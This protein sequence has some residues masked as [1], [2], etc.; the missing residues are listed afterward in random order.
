MTFKNNQSEIALP[1]KSNQLRSSVSFL[2]RFFRTEAN[3]KFLQSTLDQL[4]QPG[5]AE[6]INGYVGRKTSKAFAPSDNYISDVSKQRSDYQLEPALVIKDNIDNVIFYKDYNDYMNQLSAFGVDTANHDKIN[7]QDMY[8]WNPHIDWDKFVNFREYYWLPGGPQPVPVRAKS[9]QVIKTYQ[10]SLGE[11]DGY[12]HYIFTPDGKTANPTLKLFRGERYRFEINTPG[13]PIAFAVSRTFTPG[14]ALLVAGTEGLRGQGLYDAELFGNFYDLGDWIIDPSAGSVSFEKDQNLSTIYPDG[15]TKFDTEG[16]ELAVVYVDQGIIEFTIPDNSPDKLYYISKYDVNTSGLA[17]IFNI[18]EN[19]EKLDVVNEILGM[20]TYRSGNGIEFTNG[21]KIYFQGDVE[22]VTYSDGY[23]YVE[24]VGDQINLI[25]ERDLIIPSLYTPDTQVPFDDRPF[26]TDPFSDA[27]GYPVDKDYIVINRASL[28][29]NPWSLNNRWF[30]RQVIDYA[31]SVT[32]VPSNL[33]Q[34]LRAKRPIIE[35]EA[36]LKLYQFGTYAKSNVDLVDDYTQDVFST[37]EGSLGYNIDSIDLVDGMRVLFTADTDRLVNGRIY[38]VKFIEINGTS[39]ISL[40]NEPDT[41]PLDL[42]TV[43]VKNG[44][45]YGGKSLFFENN[46][47]NTA[48]EK[49]KRNQPPLFQLCCPSGNEYSNQAIFDSTTFKGNKIFSYAVGEGKADTELGFPL[50]YKSIENFG[51]IVFEFNLLSDKI[52]FQTNDLLAEVSTST[53]NLKKYSSRTDFVW[54]NGWNSTPIK[55]KQKVLR[56]YIATLS[57]KNMFE[58]DM[59]DSAANILDLRIKVFVN[60]KVKNETVD[61]VLTKKKEKLFVEFNKN[62][63]VNDIVLFKAYSSATKNN[64]GWYEVPVNLERNPLNNDITY[65]TLGEVNDHVDSMIEDL[66]AF[67]G[68]FPGISNLR[69]IGNLSRYGKRFVK[70]TGPLNLPIYHITNKDFNIVKAI[71]SSKREYSRFKRIF[72]ETA[73]N[74]GYD[75]P[76]KNHVDLLMKEI[77]KDKVK[78]Q[79]FYFSDMLAF[80]NETARAYQVLESGEQF[81]PLVKNFNLSELSDSSVLV[82]LNGNQLI[83]KKHYD[84]INEGFVRIFADHQEDD[85]IEIFE[86]SSTNGSFIPPTPTKLGFYPKFEP[87]IVIDDTYKTGDLDKTKPYKIYGQLDE[88]V[89]ETKGWFYPVYDSKTT[90]IK[91]DKQAGGT[92]SVNAY[93]FKGLNK[94]LYAPVSSVQ[95]ATNNTTAYEEYPVG[96]AFL[97]GHD[98]SLVKAYQDFRDDLF[99]ELEKRIFN[100]IKIEYNNSILDINDFVSGYHRDTNFSKQSVDNL[101][102]ND[103]IEW[104][105]LIDVDYTL[106]TGY[107]RDDSF[108]FNHSS[109]ESPSGSLLPGYWRGVYQQL[110]DTDR[111][112]SHPWEALGFYIKPV[113]WNQ[114]YGPAPYTSNNT[115]LW[116]DIENGIVREPN[117]Q[118]K[119]LEKYARPGLSSYIPVDEKGNLRSPIDSGFA[120]NFFFRFVTQ[121]FK[122]GDHA[123]VESAWR[124]SSEYPF[125]LLIAWTLSNPAKLL[126]LG[127]DL[128]RIEQNLSGQMVYKESGKII[129]LQDIVFPNTF[130]EDKKTLTSGL[131]NYIYNFVASNILKVYTEY[132]TQIKGI[133]NQLGFKLAGFS[134]KEKIKLILDSRSPR[135]S[136]EGGVFVPYEN[137]NLILNTS[138]PIDVV[139]YSGV[140]V[141]KVANGYVLRGYSQEN[142]YFDYYSPIISNNDRTITVGGISEVTTPWLPNKPYVKDQVIEY[143]FNFYR[144]LDNFVSSTAFSDEKL[145]KLSELP[146]VGGKRATIRKSFNKKLKLRINYGSRLSTSQDIVDFLLGYESYLLD[147][148]FKFENFNNN[149]KEIENWKLSVKEFLFWTTQ[150]WAEGTTIVLSPSANKVEFSRDFTVVDDLYDKFYD[151]SILKSDGAALEPSFNSIARNINEFGI[152]PTD[153]Q[154]GIYHIRLPLVQKEHVVIIDNKTVFGD[155]IYEPTTGYRQD[156]LEVSGYRSDNWQGSLNIPGF[157][158]DDAKIYEWE[159]WKDF[160]I[161]NIVKYK[162]FYYVAKNNVSGS[163]QFTDNDWIRLSEKPE[164]KLLTNF[165]YRTNQFNDFY[166]TDSEYFDEEQQRLAQHLTGYQ[167]REYLQNLI[168]DDSSQYKFYQGFIRE[169]GTKNSILKLFNSL[170]ESTNP[171]EFYEEWAVQLGQYGSTNSYSQIEIEI[172][173]KKVKE[174]PQIFE[175]TDNYEF[176]TDNVYRILPSEIYSKPTDFNKNF[177]P[178]INVENEFVKTAG[179]VNENDVAFVAQ[180]VDNI[181][182]ADCNQVSVN[183]YIWLINDDANGWNVLQH[184]DTPLILTRVVDVDTVAYDGRLQKE[185]FVDGLTD[186]N[187]STGEYIAIRSAQEFNLYGFYRVDRVYANKILASVP[188]DNAITDFE[189]VSLPMSKLRSIRIKD[190]NK[191]KGS[192]ADLFPKLFIQTRQQ[193]VKFIIVNDNR[194]I[195]DAR[196]IAY[197]IFTSENNLIVQLRNTSDTYIRLKTSGLNIDSINGL[198]SLVQ[199][200]KF[201]NQK[202]WIDN[203]D[204]NSW[205]VIK[206]EET[207]SQQQIL[208]DPDTNLS[209]NNKFGQSVSVT[210]DNNTLIVGDPNRENGKVYFYK[211]NRDITNFVLSQEIFLRE[212]NYFD[213]ENSNFGNSVSV[214]EDGLFLAIGIPNASN[215]KTKFKRNFELNNSYN[216]N[217]IVKYRE[218]LW[219]AVRNIEPAKQNITFTPFTTFEKLKNN[220]L[221]DNLNLLVLGNPTLLDTATDHI[222]VRAPQESFVVSK[223][224]DIL[225]LKWNSRSFLNPN[226]NIY[227]PFNGQYTQINETFISGNH[228][229]VNKV[230]KILFI[231]YPENRPPVGTIVKTSTGIGR[232]VY[233]SDATSTDTQLILYIDS[234]NGVLSAGDIPAGVLTFENG[235][236]I[237][238]YEELLND[239]YS[240][241]FGGWWLINCPSVQTTNNYLENGTGLVYVDVL[242]KN[243]DVPNIYANIRDNV[244]LRSNFISVLSYFGDPRGIIQN[245][246]SSLWVARQ[247]ES[248]ENLSA[249]QINSLSIFA[250][251]YKKNSNLDI[252]K[253]GLTYGQ[254]ESVFGKTISVIDKWIGYI[255]YVVPINS[256]ESFDPTGTLYELNINNDNIVTDSAI[257]IVQFNASGRETSSIRTKGAF[258]RKQFNNIRVYIK[259]YISGTWQLRSDTVEVKIRRDDGSSVK[260]IVGLVVNPSQNIVLSTATPLLV[261]ENTAKLPTPQIQDLTEEEY[262]FYN[263][264]NREGIELMSLPPAEN[265]LNYTQVFNINSDMFGNESNIENQGAVAIYSRTSNGLYKPETIIVSEY[266]NRFEFGK[267]V[268]ITKQND[269]YHLLV[270]CSG[271]P[272]FIEVYNHGPLDDEIYRKIWNPN[273]TYNSGDLVYFDGNF[274]QAQRDIVTQENNSIYTAELWKNVSWRSSRDK[275][276]EGEFDKDYRYA[277]DSLVIYNGNYYRAAT[278]ITPGL[279]DDT[280]WESISNGLE[281]AGYIPGPTQSINYSMFAD[282]FDTNATG[283]LIIV[284]TVDS[285][286]NI[287]NISVYRK[288]TH[289]FSVQDISSFYDEESFAKAISTNKAGT[290]FAVSEPENDEEKV[291]Q[292]KVY[293]YVYDGDRFVYNQTLLPPNNE[294]AEKF[295]HSISV[296]DSNLVVTSINGDMK[297]PATFDKFMKNDSNVGLSNKETTFDGGFT[298]FKNIKIDSGSVYVFENIKNSL[299]FGENIYND[300]L[301]PLYEG[302]AMLM[303]GESLVANDNHIYAITINEQG[304]NQKGKILDYRRDKGKTSWTIDQSIIEPADSRKIHEAFLYDKKTNAILTYVDFIDPVQGRIA[305]PADQDITYKI[306]FD[307]AQYTFNQLRIDTNLTATWGKEHVGEVWWKINSAKFA[308]AYQG[309]RQYQAAQWNKVLFGS[310]EVYEWVESN[311]PP[312]EWD[313]LADTETGIAQGISGQSLY[314]NANYSERFEYDQ[315]SQTFRSI[316]YFWVKDKK[317]VP[318]S[319]KRKVSI[320]DIKN[321]IENP[322][323]Q[324]YRFISFLGS[325]SFVLNNCDSFIKDKDTILC[326]RYNTTQKDIQNIHTEY[327]LISDGLSTSVPHEDIELKWFNS[328]IGFDANKRPVPDINLPIKDRYGIQTEPRQSMFVNRSEALKQAVERI[329]SVLIKNPVADNYNLT[330]LML[331]ELPPTERSRRYDQAVDQYEELRF[332]KTSKIKQ[333]ILKP[334][335]V[336]GKIVRISIVDPGHG[337]KISPVCEV[338][339]SGK[340]AEVEVEI[341]PQTGKVTSAKVISSGSG[342]N[343]DTAILVRHFTV[344][345]KSDSTNFGKWALYSWNS[346]QAQWNRS[347]V[348]E[349]DVRKFWNYVDWYANGYNSFTPVD[350]TIDGIY[351]L[352]EEQDR[353]GDVVKINNIGPGGWILLERLSNTQTTD[354]TINYKTI[355]R[356]NGTIQFSDTLYDY[357]K[358]TIGFDNR[359]FDSFVF[360]NVPIT[361]LRIILNTIKNDIFIGDL[362]V[363]YNQL[364]MASL[365][366]VLSE[367]PY[368]DWIFKTSFIKINHSVGKLDQDITFDADNLDDYENYVKEVKPYSTTIREFVSTYDTL[369]NTRSMITDFDTPPVFDRETGKIEVSNIIVKDGVFYNN[370][371]LVKNP[372]AGYSIV[373][374]NVADPG[375]GYTSVPKIE[376]VGSSTS[377]ASAVAYI[378][379]GKITHVE[380]TDTGSGYVSRPEIVLSNAISTKPANLSAVLGDALTRSSKISIKYDRVSKEEYLTTL[381]RVEHFVGTGSQLSFDLEWPFDLKRKSIFVFVN[382]ARA[383]KSEF[384]YE[385]VTDNKKSY[386]RTHGRIIFTNP[387]PVDSTIRVEYTVAAQ[388]LNAIDRINFFYKPTDGMPG[389][390]VYQDGKKDYSQVVTGIDYGGVE[391]TGVDFKVDTGWNSNSWSGEWD[392]FSTQSDLEANLDMI[393]T[394][395]NLTYTSAAGIKAEDI[396]IDGDELIS[397]ILNAGPEELVEGQTYDSVN[398]MVFT[399][400]N[401][402]DEQHVFAYSQFKD[403]LNRTHY[404]KYKAATTLSKVLNYY[405]ST[406]EVV[407]ASSL[408]NPRKS[409]NIPGIIFVNGERI[410]YFVKDGNILKQLRRGT[411]GTGVK[412]LHA[413]GS[414][415]VDQGITANLPY[416][417]IFE[418]Q[419]EISDGQTD[420]Y[421]LNF[422]KTS[423]LGDQKVFTQDEFEV[424]VGGVRLKKNNYNRFD[425][426]LFKMDSPEGD[427][428]AVA[429]FTVN[430]AG[431]I[432]LATTPIANQKIIIVRKIGK[433]W[434]NAGKSLY[435][436]STDIARFLKTDRS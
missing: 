20:K 368:V 243:T 146:I 236:I 139:V 331:N 305:G 380:I 381:D 332:I 327:Q 53:A 198:N 319:K 124:K 169:K 79:P 11:T 274:Y 1:T 372:N 155:T 135:Q 363:E 211:R 148:G 184:V 229:I 202:V 325:N 315:V 408:P 63:N 272:G 91:A 3:K 214:S 90:A 238:S 387:P 181:L 269:R 407:D 126:G 433:Q 241:L 55:S 247:P 290:I 265:N 292:G 49:I 371:N 314:G 8:A 69:D 263:S 52:S 76:I 352:E 423:I 156:R 97:K 165:E 130:S 268:K 188:A 207:F 174:T 127:Y 230:E 294:I 255:D 417:D 37:I 422:E 320:F 18:E 123:P 232:I 208:Q 191:F 355:G 311:Y 350:R 17:K 89:S 78:S 362:A 42:E 323:L 340:D 261:I 244:A 259:E 5:V 30:H 260:R 116:N 194:I 426:S 406:I 27:S 215:V 180:T 21:L 107:K 286:T 235:E 36:G 159:Q 154:D 349:Y 145:V 295:G 225:K 303:F 104:T 137:Y 56:Q 310:V 395:G 413:A 204:N 103:F 281:Y 432:T 324:G 326:I 2:P 200:K 328:L 179:Y 288:S 296:G 170:T 397:P 128:S 80:G 379:N 396:I 162:Q 293:V 278:N 321:L 201:K 364:F 131:V 205:A 399:K 361:E 354:Y 226:T 420:T 75:G 388:I 161:G 239:N 72:F 115:I 25:K 26:D 425:K 316:Y 345:V 158:F 393:I 306:D 394:G 398:I 119:A 199:N 217:D 277:T 318:F 196:D 22:P 83:Y 4:I 86:F 347:A 216:K 61:Y 356:Q 45:M 262:Y 106:N 298:Q 392:A 187:I 304:G 64:N 280:L 110:F 15:I 68:I 14:T 302:S 70:H 195:I 256:P 297:V 88:N 246:D 44:K 160:K 429:E 227:L 391:I 224:T 19:T 414:I 284:S 177:L 341:D 87:E 153:I 141:E 157:I 117:K 428:T 312:L 353:I 334:T 193:Q 190:I 134:E 129:N 382:N 175:I 270:S 74:L 173:E 39:Q 436:S 81:Y 301:N 149:T 377:P 125:A 7:A 257:E 209:L 231:E 385:N 150:N 31:A 416:K 427:A 210:N 421:T 82:Y 203:F 197:N 419:V 114:V 366:Y 46:K 38:K 300:F 400:A 59:Y 418:Q 98:G 51:D 338:V 424:F 13:H 307:P 99:I 102:I 254:G 33:D 16:R 178:T 376:I 240:N 66:S 374:I 94:V 411:L 122:F 333:A 403:M 105:K 308:N 283:D 223:E 111:P 358:N 32:G 120:K 92:G 172:D 271:V 285:A 136:A 85:V 348:Q 151:Y 43:F 373:K 144:A 342:Y 343:T 344:L 222:L 412:S 434:A 147:Q 405:D 189:E 409:K 249:T 431:T 109:M 164:T 245:V 248:F 142:P 410:E 9:K 317:V 378:G 24:G 93:T 250:D 176:S 163:N 140:V 167:K 213:L 220:N 383:L 273:N 360:D 384:T 351:Q 404:K 329:N 401:V 279:F 185:F 48:Q 365:R 430:N 10:V 108:T 337:Y 182:D 252:S 77:N 166:D 221:S 287:K 40:V 282:T 73:E 435:E 67:N 71:R 101:L 47:W 299:V 113:W 143:E 112:H 206:N 186:N 267:Q 357:S 242:T 359:S 60:N 322:R 275:K 62:L 84:F 168:K 336:N 258:Y 335:I 402:E 251:I 138:S 65:F 212:S 369:E 289:Y 23:W 54:V 183:D 370:D 375:E 12:Q 95:T 313:K 58:I 390:S 266:D 253:Y 330:T 389:I 228:N 276:F 35:F 264:Q 34:E 386:T 152:I 233:T 192:I 367:Q 57:T 218:K 121:N 29:R 100:N 291:N 96:I 6:K 415:V 346:A 41:E 339:G 309:T 237:G 28:D 133:Q 118:I 132:K 50:T 219:K 171:V 234:V